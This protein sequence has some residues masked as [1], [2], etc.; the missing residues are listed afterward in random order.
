MSTTTLTS[1]AYDSVCQALAEVTDEASL[2]HLADELVKVAPRNE[3]VQ[4]VVDEAHRRGI[5]TKSANTLRLYRDVAKRFA[6]SD[7]VPLVSFSA[8]REALVIGDPVA[9][10]KILLEL[11]AKVGAAGVSVTTVKSAVQAATGNV[12]APKKAAATAANPTALPA[13]IAPSWAAVMVDICTGGKDFI[14]AITPALAVRGVTLDGLAAGL[15][16]VQSE[17]DSR[18]VKAAR[19]A[20]AAAAASK[21]TPTPSAKRPAPKPSTSKPKVAA[22]SKAGDLRDL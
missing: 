20:K 1:N 10:R 2:W 14:A 9:A 19:K 11:V 18:R 3:Q 17:I 4:A 12:P 21:P 15:T 5:P 13:G 6:K 22:G 8:H 7:R 16:A